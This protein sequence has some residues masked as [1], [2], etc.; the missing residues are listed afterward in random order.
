M[1]FFS[2]PNRN[3][4]SADEQGSKQYFIS[5]LRYS[6]W[7]IFIFIFIFGTSFVYFLRENDSYQMIDLR[8]R[9]LLEAIKWLQ[10]RSLKPLISERID[11][12]Y[13]RYHVIE[14]N[15]VPGATVK[16]NRT[17]SLV[18]SYGG[19]SLVMPSYQGSNYIQAQQSLRTYLSGYKNI[20]RIT[21]VEKYSD[22]EEGLVVDHYPRYNQSIN[23]QENFIFVV[24]RGIATNQIF[25]KNYYSLDFIEVEEMLL[26][27]GVRVKAKYVASKKKVL[28]GKI[29]EQSITDG[30]PILP[31]MSIRFT[32][33]FYDPELA[34]SLK[35]GNSK[36]EVI[37]LYKLKVPIQSRLENFTHNLYNGSQEVYFA[38]TNQDEN[39][40][41]L[42]L[43]LIEVTDQTGKRILFNDR[44]KSGTVMN[45]PY[46][47]VG[48]GS[49]RVLIDGQVLETE[50]FD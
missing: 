18:V 49:L 43:I 6:F 47:T 20:P 33:G 30:M 31:G 13:P 23:F 28:A 37:R 2:K 41:S 29:V 26:S 22:L 44:L 15:P 42:R 7:L 35:S 14:Q 27:Y 36:I 32:V 12:N 50:S 4:F 1:S 21:K 39:S 46:R 25:A 38:P 10:D 9:D 16:E 17:I 48:E 34:E 24:S 11:P 3:H 5:L 40:D 45:F 8:G 19:N